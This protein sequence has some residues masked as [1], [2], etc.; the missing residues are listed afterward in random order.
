MAAELGAGLR[1]FRDRWESHRDI[2]TNV[3]LNKKQ[4]CTQ[5]GDLFFI[6]SV[7]Q[8]QQPCYPSCPDGPRLVG[9]LGLPLSGCLK[10]CVFF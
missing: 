7:L 9:I 3:R 4:I 10:L 6:I 5:L 2:S 1:I 8:A